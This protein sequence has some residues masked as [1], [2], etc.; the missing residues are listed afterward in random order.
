[1]SQLTR[2]DILDRLAVGENLRGASL[3]RADLSELDLTRIDLTGANLRMADLSRSDMKESRL[4][5]C[6]LSG[7][8]LNGTNLV[9][10]N[11]VEASLIGVLLK[12]GDL[13]RADLSGADLTGANLE[14]AQL[15]GAYLVGAFLNETDLN[16]A[17]LSGAFVRMAQMAGCILS[18]AVMEG[19]DFSHADLSGVRFDGGSLVGATLAGANLS[20]STLLNCDLRNA[21]LTGADL[22]GCNLTG[23]KLSGIKFSGVK[24]NDTW[25]EWVDLSADG[26]GEERATLIH[27]FANLMSNPLAQILIQGRVND[28]AWAVILAHLCDFRSTHPNNSDV[29]MK[30]IHQGVSSSAL[31]LEASSESSLVAYFTEFANIMGKGSE[32]LLEK[33]DA[34]GS[35]RD[36]GRPARSSGSLL[37]SLNPLEQAINPEDPLDLQMGSHAEAMQ[38]TEFWPSEKAIVILT[39]DRKIWLEAVSSESLTLRPPPGSLMGVDLIRG[40]FVTEEI[41]RQQQGSPVHR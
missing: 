9:G 12:G 8:T 4:T 37:A 7:A 36:G 23:A 11:L 31:Y 35:G 18:G 28:E 20:A 34:T 21:D 17:N 22:S 24:L 29:R 14:S 39:G 6:S 30:A 27:V 16:R 38:S 25:A 3:V 33:L 40:R 19:A 15:A 10:A 2:G 32:E 13:S 5:S 26:K 1:M 41:R